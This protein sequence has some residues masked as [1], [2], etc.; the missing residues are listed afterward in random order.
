M[1]AL[2]EPVSVNACEKAVLVVDQWCGFVIEGDG[3]EE[4]DEVEYVSLRQLVWEGSWNQL[5]QE[6]GHAIEHRSEGGRE[7]AD[8]RTAGMESIVLSCFFRFGRTYALGSSLP[9]PRNH[10]CRSVRT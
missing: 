7:E 8:D 10:G 4:L 9:R 2:N 6:L 3:L 1:P 5:V